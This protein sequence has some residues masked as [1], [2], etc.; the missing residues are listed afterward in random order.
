MTSL[1]YPFAIQKSSN[2][3]LTPLTKINNPRF[4]EFDV[5]I[6]VSGDLP[7]SVSILLTLVATDDNITDRPGKAVQTQ[8]LLLLGTPIFR[9]IIL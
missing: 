2:N 6:D 4:T 7:K 1:H 5:K 9:V 8:E 3:S